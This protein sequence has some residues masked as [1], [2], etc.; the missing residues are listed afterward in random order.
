MRLTLLPKGLQSGLD[1]AGLLTARLM[2][3]RLPAARMDIIHIIRMRARPMATTDRVGSRA[4]SSS[5]PA[6]GTTDKNAD[7][8]A[9]MDSTA[10]GAITVDRHIGP[11]RWVADT[12]TPVAARLAVASIASVEVPS[13]A[14]AAVST[15]AVVPTG[16]AVVAADAGSI[17]L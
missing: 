12:A 17:G 10:A 16:E 9:A 3:D 1:L 8:M 13:A 4:A 15:G 2:S 5:V 7:I 11:A 6:L 14:E